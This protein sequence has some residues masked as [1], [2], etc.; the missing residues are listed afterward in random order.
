MNS[1][2]ETLLRAAV[3]A[4]SGDNLQPWQFIVDSNDSTMHVCV[5]QSRDRSPMNAG[6]R[7]ARLACGAAIENILRTA[8]YNGWH[9]DLETYDH[10][11]RLATLR[12]TEHPIGVGRIEDLLTLRRTNR[13][14]YDGTSLSGEVIRRLNAATSSSRIG[15]TEW[16]TDRE[17]IN[18]FADLVGDADAAM[19][20]EKDF[21]TAFS[22]SICFGAAAPMTN[23]GLAIESLGLTPLEKAMLPVMREL[24]KAVLHSRVAAKGFRGRAAKLV[25]SASCLCAIISNVTSY[26]SDVEVGRELQRTWLTLTSLGFDVQPMMSLPVISSAARHEQ[27]S[28]LEEAASLGQR[29][30]RLLLG[31]PDDVEVRALLRLGHARSV[32]PKASRLPIAASVVTNEA[33][34]ALECSPITGNQENEP[35]HLV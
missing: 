12:L 28:F 8:S 22:D 25:R 16:I 7:M 11:W 4:P 29:C 27:W 15:K 9:I 30:A 19:F 35:C 31:I 24:P 23:R 21:F 17:R 18:A 13:S 32:T 3:L 33:V 26:D 1:H 20:R 34:P 2:V 10:P 14:L 5:D 6:Q